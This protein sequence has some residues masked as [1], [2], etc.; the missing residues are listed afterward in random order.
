MLLLPSS[1]ATGAAM[2]NNL[3]TNPVSEG[4]PASAAV[5]P[6]A[7]KFWMLP[8]PHTGLARSGLRAFLRL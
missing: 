4:L 2:Q 1:A 5:P 6:S 8:D 7:T 3:Q